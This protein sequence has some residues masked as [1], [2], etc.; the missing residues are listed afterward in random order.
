MRTPKLDSTPRRPERTTCSRLAGC[1]IF[2]GDCPFGGPRRG[3]ALFAAVGNDSRSYPE[4]L[5]PQ[6]RLSRTNAGAS[7]EAGETTCGAAHYG[8]TVWF[9]FNTTKSGRADFEVTSFD[10]VVSVYRAGGDRLACNDN[11]G[12]ANTSEVGL[13]VTPGSYLVQVGGKG[14]R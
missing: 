10:T 2:P 12:D 3:V 4:T 6:A 13:N 5:Q 11:S 1:D 9:R 14:D 7:T 8:K